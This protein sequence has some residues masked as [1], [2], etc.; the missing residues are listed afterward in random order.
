MTITW[1]SQGL[2]RKYV[3]GFWLFECFWFFW[4]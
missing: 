2:L 1:L 4:I 3:C